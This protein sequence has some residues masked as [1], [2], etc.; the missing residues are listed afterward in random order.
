[1]SV[2]STH[3]CSDCLTRPTEMPATGFAIG[4][5]AAISP[6]VAPQ[7]DAIELEPFDSRMSE[8]TRMV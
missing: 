4:T 6:S 1:M 8:M 3:F 7:T 5:P 2:S